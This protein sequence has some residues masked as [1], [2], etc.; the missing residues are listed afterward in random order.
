MFIYLFN[1]NSSCIPT[2]EPPKLDS[3]KCL[4]LLI[5]YSRVNHFGWSIV[6]YPFLLPVLLEGPP[7]VGIFTIY[8]PKEKKGGPFTP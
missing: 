2:H 5:R 6:D 4:P 7:N 1:V 3:R 8:H